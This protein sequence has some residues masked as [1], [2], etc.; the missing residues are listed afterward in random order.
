MPL[1]H[2]LPASR[3][4]QLCSI[5]L[6]FFLNSDGF[7]WLPHHSRSFT[8]AMQLWRTP[9]WPDLAA[10]GVSTGP[11]SP[12]HISRELLACLCTKAQTLSQIKQSWWIEPVFPICCSKNVLGE[13]CRSLVREVG[14]SLSTEGSRFTPSSIMQCSAGPNEGRFV[15]DDRDVLCF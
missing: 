2:L 13:G 8:Q 5:C 15:R 9:S 4:T 3:R 6:P 7:V 12:G 11:P 14:W 1:F 10:C